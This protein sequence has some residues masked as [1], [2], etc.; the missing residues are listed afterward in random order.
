VAPRTAAANAAGLERAHRPYRFSSSEPAPDAREV[1]TG[2]VSRF[3]QDRLG[4]VRAMAKR[5]KVE[6]PKDVERFFAAVEAGRW[7]ELKDLFGSL[8]KLRD[9][10]EAPEDFRKLWPAILET[11]GVAEAAH[12]WPAQKLLDYGEAVLGSLRPDMVYVGGTDSG[13]FIPTLLNETSD[14]ERH[15]VLTQNALADGTYLE[16]LRFLYSDRITT[17]TQ[18]DSQCAFQDYMSDAEKR[19]AHDQQFPDEPKQVRPGEDIHTT[20]GHIQVSGQMSVMAINEKLFQ[21]MMDKN[22]NLSFA[23]EESFPFKST[24]PNAVPL[25]PIMELGVPDAQ[26]TFTAAAA[27]Q[28]VDYW[29][30]A[31]QSLLEGSDNPGDSAVANTYSKM[32]VA[33]AKLLESHNFATEAEQ[34]YRLATDM[35]PSSPQAVFCYAGFLLGQKR[36]A[37]AI[38]V[39]ETAVNGA[40]DN[41]QLRDLLQNLKRVAGKN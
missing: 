35:A 31:S 38:P 17:L 6:V 1:V 33:Q 39:V 16:Y 21:M 10:S 28:A 40:P 14:G 30:A 34:T 25:G 11:F 20:D 19:Y 5:Y 4:V 37:E 26:K 3:A 36:F 2:K 29:R 12:D 18:E 27:A 7:E 32:A 9:S 8:K 22:P 23:L 15:V 13:R 24:Y 41:Q